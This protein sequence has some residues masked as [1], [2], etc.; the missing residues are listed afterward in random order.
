MN[1]LI[2]P[3]PLLEARLGSRKAASVTSQKFGRR[4][5]LPGDPGTIWQIQQGVIRALSWHE[6]GS[7][8]T[9]GLWGNGDLVGRSLSRLDPYYLECLTLVKA[10]PLPAAVWQNHPPI[11]LAHLHQL[12]ILTLIRSQRRVEDMLMGLLNWLGTKFGYISPA[13]CLIDLRITH[14]DLADMLS[15]TR[16]T[17]TRLLNKL[18]TQGFI[19]RHSIRQIVLKEIDS[20]YYEI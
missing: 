14:Q 9:L 12:E 6:D 15:T 10:I 5:Y 1:N 4:S 17:I 20:W 3:T 19:E 18:E 2:H 11:L 16:V 8:V 13:G 7:V